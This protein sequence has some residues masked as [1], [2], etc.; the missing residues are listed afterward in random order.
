MMRGGSSWRRHAVIAL[1]AALGFAL[2]AQIAAAT[3]PNPRNGTYAG[4]GPMEGNPQY[5]VELGFTVKGT[6][7]HSV[8]RVF[9]LPGCSGGFFLP[10]DMTLDENRFAGQSVTTMPPET[11]DIK[12]R[13]VTRT[14]IKGKVTL[15]REDPASCGDPGTYMY[16]FS[17]RRYGKP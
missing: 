8:A 1:A 6:N 2:P 14:R 7:V 17:A 12:A 10:E 16:K 13:F 4:A 9:T 3:T 11:N 15:T 5:G